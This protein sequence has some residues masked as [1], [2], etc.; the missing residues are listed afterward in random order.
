MKLINA[1]D[2]RLIVIGKVGENGATAV[3]FNCADWVAEYGV[4]T[5]ALVHKRNIDS[6][7]YPC[8]VTEE[9]GIVSWVIGSADLAS[10]GVGEAQ[11]SLIVDDVVVKSDIYQTVTLPSIESSEEP[12]EAW[13]AWVDSVFEATAHYPVPQNGNWHIWVNGRYIDTGV[14]AEAKDGKT[15]VKGV[16]YFDG[17]DGHT[18]IK[19][20][21][22]TD[23]KDG[24][25]PIKGVDYTDGHTPTNEEI[26]AIIQ[27]E[28]DSFADADSRLTESIAEVSERVDDIGTVVDEKVF[29]IEE[30]L[31]ALWKLSEG[32]V[33]DYIEQESEAYEVTN[34]SGSIEARLKSLSGKSIVW[35][36]ISPNPLSVTNNAVVHFKQGTRI[37]KGHKYFLSAKA[38]NWG[39]YSAFNVF[40]KN[41]NRTIAFAVMGRDNCKGIRVAEENGIADGT[42]NIGSAWVYVY[43]NSSK[44]I[45]KDTVIVDLTM[46]YGE[47]NEPTSITDQRIEFIERYASTHPEYNDGEIISADVEEMVENG[48]NLIDISDIKDYSKW[49]TD[50]ATSGGLTTN[51]GN[52]GYILP[53]VPNTKYTISKPSTFSSYYLYLC[54][55]NA[56]KE[57]EQLAYLTTNNNANDTYT[58]S[59]ADGETA[60]LRCGSTNTKNEFDNAFGTI[61]WIQLERGTI[62]T[63]YAPYHRT[64]HPLPTALTTIDGW[65]MS[66]GSVSNELDL[67]RDVW[68]K[69]VGCVDLGTLNYIVNATRDSAKHRFVVTDLSKLTDGAFKAVFGASTIA[70]CLAKKYQAKSSNDTYTCVDGISLDNGKYIYIY[71]ENYAT[72]TGSDFKASVSGVL[73]YYELADPIETDLHT[74]LTEEE[75]EELHAFFECEGGGSIEFAQADG[76]T[77]PVKNTMEYMRKLSEV[78]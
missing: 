35:N 19:G 61:E 18:P 5:F 66:A 15:P 3:L 11:L 59:V 48:R 77:I 71:D 65:G 29:P 57:G 53:C 37:I 8:F 4:G 56:N 21:D 41:E 54:K 47:G 9:S 22:Y 31:D 10:V 16:D 72:A 12:P 45:T 26:K 32:I 46:L 38:E 49:R 36:Q 20:V 6:D 2:N 23:G 64:E 27:P 69:R 60:F 74:I 58:F 14:R 24:Y 30:K 73:M 75:L 63:P 67:K 55:V 25:T 44:A 70:N 52:R 13:K 33:Y 39:I 34:P 7:G 76:K 68:V 51:I 17:K 50:I 28:L 62:A 40:C 1:E 78:V 42:Q 43:G